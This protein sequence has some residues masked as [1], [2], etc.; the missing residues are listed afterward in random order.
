M[1]IYD[2]DKDLNAAEIDIN[3]GDILTIGEFV[4][5]IIIGAFSDYDG[6]AKFI[7]NAHDKLYELIDIDYSIYLDEIFLDGE[8]LGDLI[9]FCS[10]HHIYKVIWYNK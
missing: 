5:N 6:F 2:C 3:T 4:D 1:R 10:N 7:V 9:S 8:V